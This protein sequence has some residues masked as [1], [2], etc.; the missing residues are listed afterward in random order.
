MKFFGPTTEL[1]EIG[2]LIMSEN[3][4]ALENKVSMGLDLNAKVKITDHTEVTPLIIALCENKMKVV[5]W[6]LSKKVDLNDKD[7]PAILMACSN[8]NAETIKELIRRGADVNA[9][10]KIGKSAMNEALYGNNFE[11]ISILIENGYDIKKDG[12]SFRQAV[13]SRQH[14]AVKMFL[15]YGVDVN[16]CEP[17]MVFP[18]NSSPV[19]VAAKNNDLE[20]V[21][22]LVQHGADVTRKD[23]YGE[24][25]Y[26]CAVENKNE[27]LMAFIKSLEPEKWHNEEQKIYDLKKYK[28]PMELLAIMRSN[29]RRIEIPENS[30]VKYIIFHSLLDLKEVDWKKHKFLDL[31]SEVDNY[32]HGG[33]LVWYPK[34]KCLAFADYEHEEFKE[35]CSLKDFFAFPS[36]QID[37]IFS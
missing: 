15:N 16:Y 31:L 36:L 9:R 25:P 13:D 37:K 7:Y 27:A 2:K 30:Y 14:Q 3:I 10:H 18:Y 19:H 29:N 11:A 8:C 20:T 23:N 22:L 33:F 26:N 17:D 35:L 5:D 1:T 28:I 12:V 32:S 24:R 21:K 34:K 6:L 4:D